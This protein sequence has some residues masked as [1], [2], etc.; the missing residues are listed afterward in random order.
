MFFTFL[1]HKE[2]LLWAGGRAW[3][4]LCETSYCFEVLLLPDILSST[5]EKG[6]PDEFIRIQTLIGTD[7]VC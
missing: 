2:F 4:F 5:I 1:A 6:W 3:L 7:M